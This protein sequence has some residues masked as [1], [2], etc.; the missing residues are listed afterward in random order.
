MLRTCYRAIGSHGA[1]SWE[2]MVDVAMAIEGRTVG[3]LGGGGSCWLLYVL[4]VFGL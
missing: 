2:V 4:V 1:K 3:E